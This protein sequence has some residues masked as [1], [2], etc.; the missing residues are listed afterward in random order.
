MKK[1]T[2]I[3]ILSILLLW[4]AIW[5]VD[6]ARVIL[7]KTPVFCIKT[8]DSHYKGLGYAFD[9]YPHPITGD[10]E[11][12]AYVFGEMVGSNFTN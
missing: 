7:E 10:P 4:F 12:A 3:T 1:K 2:I 5:Q 9:I 6:Y 8:Q 11:Y